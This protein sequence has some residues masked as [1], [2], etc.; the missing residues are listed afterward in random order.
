MGDPVCVRH[1]FLQRIASGRARGASYEAQ[2]EDTLDALASHLEANMDLDRLL[3]AA[4]AVG[5]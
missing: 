1:A 4:G 2:V 5:G 3:A